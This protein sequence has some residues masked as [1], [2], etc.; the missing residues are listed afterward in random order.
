MDVVLTIL[1]VAFSGLGFAVDGLLD[2][3]PAT[4]ESDDAD[5]ATYVRIAFDPFVFLQ[6]VKRLRYRPLPSFCFPAKPAVRRGLAP[7]KEGQYCGQIFSAPWGKWW[8]SSHIKPP[9]F[10]VS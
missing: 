1:V 2:D 7:S 3:S 9:P 4:A 10:P 6:A 8:L 5:A